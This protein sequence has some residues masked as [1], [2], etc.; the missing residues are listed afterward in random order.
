VSAYKR[1][2]DRERQV[3]RLFRER[4]WSATRSAGSHGPADVVCLREGYQPILV[5]VKTDTA[6]PWAHFGPQE[7]RELREEA[8]R[9]GARALLLH[10]PPRGTRKFIFEEGWPND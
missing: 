2:A 7:R 9:A 8:R 6:G 10:W 5:Q 3:V 1:G 4:G